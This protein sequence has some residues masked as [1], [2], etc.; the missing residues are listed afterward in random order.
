MY[1]TMQRVRQGYAC[2]ALTIQYNS[3][4]MR[5]LSYGMPLHI[6]ERHLRIEEHFVERISPIFTLGNCSNLHAVR[7]VIHRSQLRKVFLGVLDRNAFIGRLRDCMHTRSVLLVSSKGA[8]Y[9][10]SRK[11][12]LAAACSVQIHEGSIACVY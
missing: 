8:P 12:Y 2:I 5:A 4:R 11:P 1:R 10:L 6:L 3:P 9:R 7:F